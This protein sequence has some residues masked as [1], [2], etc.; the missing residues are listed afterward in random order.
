M[1][2]DIIYLVNSSKLVLGTVYSLKKVKNKPLKP[3]FPTCNHVNTL[4]KSDQD[5]THLIDP[6]DI[7][8]S[9]MHFEYS[10]A[11][12]ATLK[13]PARHEM[14]SEVDLNE[15]STGC[16]LIDYSLEN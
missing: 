2:H 8:D 13:E 6:V 12:F 7:S 5:V 11:T 9:K 14:H 4:M 10:D 1:H 15:I 16:E 3:Q